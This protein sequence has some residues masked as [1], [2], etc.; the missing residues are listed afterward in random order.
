MADTNYS[1]PLYMLGAGIPFGQGQSSDPMS[2]LA[3]GPLT[4]QNPWAGPDPY[5]SL[6]GGLAPLALL[7][8]QMRD[9]PPVFAGTAPPSHAS[10][11]PPVPFQVGQPQVM[12]PLETAQLLDSLL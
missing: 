1:D 7:M 4:G 3:T 12:Q 9:R 10:V 6:L 11:N 2:A 5:V 8:T